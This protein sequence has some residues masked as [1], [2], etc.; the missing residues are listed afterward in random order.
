MELS[1]ANQ[2]KFNEILK[3]YPVKR[4]AILP[5][6]FM[7]QGQQGYLSREAIECVAKLLE[8]TP[9]QVHDAAS[10]YSMFHFKPIGQTLIEVC[11]NLSCALHGADDLIEKTCQRLGIKEGGTTEDGEYELQRIACIGCCALAPT[12]TVDGEVHARVTPR[13]VRSIVGR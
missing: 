8:L 11:T 9:A 13:K 4:S 1:S 2:A 5:A 3:R 10:Y 12:V 7:V 6:L